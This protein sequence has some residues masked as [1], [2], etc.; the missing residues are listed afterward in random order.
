MEEWEEETKQAGGTMGLYA[1]GRQPPRVFWHVRRGRAQK[2]AEVY[3]RDTEGEG[4][5]QQHSESHGGGDD[6]GSRQQRIGSGGDGE[7][8]RE[9]YDWNT[10]V[11][12][13]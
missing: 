6:E 7:H 4:H 11:Q 9:R 12:A 2:S 8:Q 13:P 1:S 10:L 3:S 5:H